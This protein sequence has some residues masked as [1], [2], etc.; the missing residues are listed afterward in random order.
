MAQTEATT[1]VAIA[2]GGPAGIM[3]G[4]LLARAGVDVTVCEKHA[5]FLRDFRGD[6]VHPSTLQLLYELGLSEEFDRLPHRKVREIGFAAR[7]GRL[8]GTDL[9]TLP[10]RYQYIALTPQW[11]FLNLLTEHAKTY[12]G[13]HLLMESEVT[14]V[15]RIGDRAHG[16]RYRDANGEH[17]LRSALTVAA[18][19]RQSVLRKAAGL[20]PTELGVPMDVLWMRLSRAPS[21]PEG[22]LARVGP[23]RMVI[24][25]D[26]GDYWQLGYLVAKGSYAEARSAGLSAL[27]DS[28]AE[29]EPFLGDRVGELSSWDDIAMLNVGLNRLPR[30]YRHGLLCIGDAAHTMS[31]IGGVGINLAI[32]DGVATANLLYETLLE[33]RSAGSPHPVEPRLLARV[34][35]RRLPPTVGTQALQGLLQRQV[36]TRVLRGESPRTPP[37]FLGDLPARMVRRVFLLGLLPEHVRTP[38]AAPSR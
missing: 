25:I 19:G 29:L 28:I 10:G 5:D 12:P 32:Q 15:I 30:W 33:R 23:G 38:S 22:L 1:T 24:G 6:T 3:L 21:D 34:E 26:R 8:F 4:L 7:Q 13:F 18:D 37:A 20:H 16:V 2:G 31:P 27:R 11:N 36:L 14:G 9:S 35:R 17:E